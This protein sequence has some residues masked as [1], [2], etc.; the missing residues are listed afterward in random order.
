[1]TTIKTK[2]A[3]RLT[4]GI[5]MLL[6]ATSPVATPALAQTVDLQSASM[7]EAIDDRSEEHTSNSSH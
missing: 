4:A 5:L 7:A 2:R 6:A 1:M 3:G